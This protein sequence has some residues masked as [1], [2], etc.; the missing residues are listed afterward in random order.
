MAATPWEWLALGVG[1]ALIAVAVFAVPIRLGIGYGEVPKPGAPG[2][3]F[4][5]LIG[6]GPLKARFALRR[7]GGVT[8]RPDATLPSQDAGER[9][10]Q[11]ARAAQ[12][13]RSA[14]RLIRPALRVI[15]RFEWRTEL[16]AGDAAATGLLAGALWALKATV[17]GVLAREHVFLQAPRLD[18]VPNFRQ[19]RFALEICC[20]FRFT[21]GDI[22]LGA[23]TPR[24]I[25]PKG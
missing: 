13:A 8:T 14:Y 4:W 15:E 9:W 1:L 3:R 7:P 19:T 2:P 18:V 25:P 22:I 11:A 16:G 17:V 24:A 5:I 6:A 10:R 21:L 23:R 20:I 12:R